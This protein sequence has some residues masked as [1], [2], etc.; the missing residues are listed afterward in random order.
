MNKSIKLTGFMLLGIGGIAGLYSSQLA[1]A[2]QTLELEEVIV[3]AQKREQNLQDISVSVSVVDAA[4]IQNAQM[5][6][7]TDIARLA[8]NINVSYFGLPDQPKFSLRGAATSDFNLNTS[9]ATG[10]LV[11]EVFLAASYFGGPLMLDIERIEALRGPQGTLFGK[12]T[13]GGAIQFI[14]KKPSFEPG[15]YLKGSLGDYNYQ[16]I[17]GAGELILVEDRLAARLAFTHSKSDGFWENE[18]PVG[19]DLGNIDNKAARLS[20]LY[21]GDSWDAVLR[22]FYSRSTP[23]AAGIINE[24]SADDGSNVLGV[25]PRVSPITGKAYDRYQGYWDRS[26]DIDVKTDGGYLTVHKELGDY[27]LSSVSSYITGSFL[28]LVDTDGS[29]D[30]ILH[31]DFK[32][33]SDE[34]S[35]DL[36]LT[37]DLP[38]PFNFIAGLYYFNEQASIPTRYHFFADIPRDQ[39]PPSIAI[40]P[41]LIELDFEQERESHAAYFSGNYELNDALSVNLGLRWTEDKGD[42]IDYNSQ[43]TVLFSWMVVGPVPL[44]EDANDSYSDSEVTGKIGLD[45]NLESGALLYTHYATGF[46]SSAFDGSALF[47]S[48][49]LSKA[50]PEFIETVEV[51]YKTDF[52]DGRVRLNSALFFSQYSDMQFLNVISI[53]EQELVNLDAQMYGLEVEALTLLAEGLTLSAGLGYLQGEYTDDTPING[54]SVKGNDLLEAPELNANLAIDFETAIA[55]A[56]LLKFHIDG[57]FVDDQYFDFRNSADLSTDSYW[58]VNSKLTLVPANTNLEV[59]L[60]VKNLGDN[61]EYVGRIRDTISQGVFSVAPQPRRF[62]AEVLWTF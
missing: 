55:T 2:Q 39:A 8:P 14:T 44:I 51:G 34:I 10:V 26:G 5:D 49:Q 15:G 19:D 31:I 13:T 43:A 22:L 54:A 50:K 21:Q 7:G 35:Q 27:T 29:K 3:T 58:S 17:D 59:S 4:L 52:I 28:N 30:N 46:R 62:G 23:K 61:D 9:S 45:Y 16:H 32:A 48:T 57:N 36:R 20:V 11:D 1:A 38:G 47:S 42:L 18:N 33:S 24:G 56:G 53:I 60:W 37:S 40:I 25:N 6:N 12:N 41:N